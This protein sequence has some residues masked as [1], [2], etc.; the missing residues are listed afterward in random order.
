MQNN[1]VNES[2]IN[3]VDY[4][5]MA[6]ANRDTDRESRYVG[7]YN[8]HIL[9]PVK[10]EDELDNPNK[11]RELNNLKSEVESNKVAKEEAENAINDLEEILKNQMDEIKN[12]KR[13]SE[14]TKLK[15]DI[16]KKIKE[17]KE[18]KKLTMKAITSLNRSIDSNE[19][20]IEKILSKANKNKILESYDEDE[21]ENDPSLHEDQIYDEVYYAL[22]DMGISDDVADNLVEKNAELIHEAEDQNFTIV[23]IAY[24]LN[25]RIENN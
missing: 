21:Y 22:R 5:A 6:R 10:K 20:K 23:E 7:G 13:D 1:L 4:E 18:L 9:P 16:E 14:A 11:R 24:M 17:T 19:K 8:R 15:K 25:D 2:I 12:V 3:E